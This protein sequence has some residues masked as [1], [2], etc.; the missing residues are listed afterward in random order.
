M[1]VVEAVLQRTKEQLQYIVYFFTVYSY[2]FSGTI[3]RL[4]IRFLLPSN[5]L[6]CFV[7][8]RSRFTYFNSFF[9]FLLGKVRAQ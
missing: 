4:L 3:C 7:Y 6:E 9:H 8:F 1:L 2:F 5:S